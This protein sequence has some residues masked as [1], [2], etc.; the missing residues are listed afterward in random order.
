MI[1]F[2]FLSCDYIYCCF[3]YLTYINQDDD[4]LLIENRIFIVYRYPFQIFY[5]IAERL[6]ISDKMGSQ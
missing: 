6:N 1:F 3:E 4:S 2:L 5:F